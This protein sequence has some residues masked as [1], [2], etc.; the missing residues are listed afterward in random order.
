MNRMKAEKG[1][2]GQAL[3]E[4]AIVV[5]I[6]IA[7]LSGIVDFGAVLNGWITLSSAAREGARQAS[8][9]RSVADVTAAARGFSLVAGVN[10]ANV[11]VSVTYPDGRNP[12]QTGDRVTV[13]VQAAQFPITTPVVVAAFRAAG[14]CGGGGACTIPLSS[15]TTMRSEGVFIP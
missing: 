6:F 3:V 10:P 15:S 5:T 13:T 4:F 14:Q 8:I 1:E 11:N 7:L 12:P 9:G 2:R